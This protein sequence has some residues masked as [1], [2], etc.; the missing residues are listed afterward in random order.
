VFKAFTNFSRPGPVRGCLLKTPAL[1]R[2]KNYKRVFLRVL[3]TVILVGLLS[4]LN[5]DWQQ[6]G[7]D[8]SHANLWLALGS[9]GLIFPIIGLKAW[10]WKFI[11]GNYRIKILLKE[12]TGLYGLGLSAGSVTPGQVGDFIKALSLQDKGYSLAKGMAST[13]VDRL[14]DMFV[15]VLLA[16]WGLLQL[17]SGFYGDLPLLLG[18]LALTGLGLLVLVVPRLST[19]IFNDLLGKVLDRKS[20]KGNGIVQ[21]EESLENPASPYRQLGLACIGTSFFLTL[22]TAGLAVGRTWLLALA[23]GANISFMNVLAISTLATIAS[24]VP[25]TIGGIGVRDLALV[26]IMTQLGYPG[27]LAVSLSTL[28]LLVNLLNFPAGYIVWFSFKSSNGLKSG[29]NLK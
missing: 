3:I 20:R 25:F 17:G 18:F 28:L 12:A 2:P 7:A 1:S 13:L 8:L 6:I 9:V 22:A 26:T 4:R 23:L 29:A 11:L 5:L 19:F 27:Y 21:L 15:L 24:L 14:F 16:L 10:R